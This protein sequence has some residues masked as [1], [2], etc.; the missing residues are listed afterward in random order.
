MQ[1]YITLQWV[2]ANKTFP[3]ERKKSKLPLKIAEITIALTI[4]LPTSS[5]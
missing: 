5:V 3:V 1:L 4:L 2:G